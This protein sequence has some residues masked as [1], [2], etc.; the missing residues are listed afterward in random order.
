MNSKLL[1]GLL[2]GASVMDG[3]LAGGGI[4]RA[5]VHM[6]AWRHVGPVAWAHFSRYAD[7][8]V[9]AMILY[10]LEAFSGMVLSVTAAVVF[11]RRYCGPR[12]VALPLYSA[13]IFTIGGLLL[14]IKAAPIRLSVGH[15]G[16]DSVAMQR[17][18]DGFEFW[19]GWR[20]ACQVLGFFANLL[21]LGAIAHVHTSRSKMEAEHGASDFRK[22]TEVS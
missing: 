1:I 14:T 11:F 19:G 12:S 10:P 2:I 5:F 16:D 4:N 7:L 17:A 18:F 20:S 8:S 3:S 22:R 6:P 21:A 13:A 15:L 9:N